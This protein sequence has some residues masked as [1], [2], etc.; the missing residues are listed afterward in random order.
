MNL[1]IVIIVWKYET[2]S[3]W[4]FSCLELGTEYSVSNKSFLHVPAN[5]MLS[6]FQGN[7]KSTIIFLKESMHACNSSISME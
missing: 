7:R 4:K 5:I 1:M 6:F 2:H 3:A